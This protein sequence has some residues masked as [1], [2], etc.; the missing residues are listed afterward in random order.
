MQPIDEVALA[1]LWDGEAILIK[2][3]HAGEADEREPFSAGWLLRQV[4]KEK[5]IFRD[6]GIAATMLSF[7]AL[8]PPLL[9]MVIVDRIL[10]HQ[11]VSS[12]FV[13]FVGI[14]FF[15][16]F[17][18]AFGWLRRRLIAD[19]SARIDARLGTYLFDRIIGLPVDVF[20]RL[21]T[22][23]ITYKIGEVWRIRNFLT[24]QLFSTALDSITLVVLIPVMFWLHAG[25]TFFVLGISLLMFL[26]VIAYIPAMGR[27]YAKVVHAE[28]VKNS[29]LVEVI[30][31][32]RTVKSLALEG[33][34]RR[35]WDA[36]AAGAVRAH[37]SMQD[38]INQPQTLLQP[39]EKLSYAGTLLLGSYLILDGGQ[40]TLAGTLVAFTMIAQRTTQPFMQIAGL[41]QRIWR[42]WPAT[43][44]RRSDAS[45]RRSP[46]RS[47][48][49]S[50]TV[51][52][53]RA[54]RRC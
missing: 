15:L 23:L 7:F 49:P 19:G 50:A 39:L 42:A 26:V 11:R 32:M 8:A 36:K 43:C 9:Y 14:L 16:A 46:T 21:P 31:G 45:S 28:Q 44:S 38:L 24:G 13:L 54:S 18:T 5:R 41:M 1:E 3:D 25:M 35:D 53:W 30:H 47:G 48:K 6:V 34:K 22:G 27:A 4:L 37:Q 12:L 52:P 40:A 20:E 17:D 33:S 10:V 29:F 51:L 2:R